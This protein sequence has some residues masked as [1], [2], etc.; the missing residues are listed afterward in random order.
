[1]G[2]AA[3]EAKLAIQLAYMEQHPLYG[4]FVDL[5]KAFGSID[6]PRCLTIL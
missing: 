2:N 5:W 3:I 4:E 6:R 1:M